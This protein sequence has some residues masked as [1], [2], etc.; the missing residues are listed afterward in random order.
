[1]AICPPLLLLEKSLLF[2]IVSVSALCPLP[3][4]L[5]PAPSL[6]Y[7][8]TALP[9]ISVIVG[10]VS[11]TLAWTEIVKVTPALCTNALT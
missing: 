7:I 11:M 9:V 4:H 10:C 2:F 1:M 8:V 6:L 3:S 5:P